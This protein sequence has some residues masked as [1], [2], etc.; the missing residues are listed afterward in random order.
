VRLPVYG[1]PVFNGAGQHGEQQEEGLDSTGGRAFRQEAQL[2]VQVAVNASGY[3]EG[4]AQGVFRQ[5]QLIGC[6]IIQLAEA[7]E[8]LERETSK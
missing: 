5:H 2:D 3:M 4:K 1:Y 6:F 8:I 7:G